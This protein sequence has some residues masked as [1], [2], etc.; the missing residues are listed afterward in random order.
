[1]GLGMRYL[2]AY[3]TGMAA[4]CSWGTAFLNPMTPE[5]NKWLPFD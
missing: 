1:M 2:F 4:N 5:A 3:P